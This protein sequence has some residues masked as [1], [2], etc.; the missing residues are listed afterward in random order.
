M[1]APIAGPIAPPRYCAPE[2]TLSASLTFAS[3][4]LTLVSATAAGTNPE[5]RPCSASAMPTCHGALMMLS[6]TAVSAAKYTART[7][8]FLRPSR[9]DSSPQSGPPIKR[10]TPC[11]LKPTATQNK[12]AASSL[13]P[14]CS[15]YSGRNGNHTFISSDVLPVALAMARTARLCRACAGAAVVCFILLQ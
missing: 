2:T 5:S 4:T 6:T 8:I 11:A 3:G 10:P 15:M 7:N 12:A 14:T 9:S 13:A 1:A